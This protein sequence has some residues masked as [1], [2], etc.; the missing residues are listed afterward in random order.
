LPT[1]WKVVVSWGYFGEGVERGEG[2]EGDTF[3]YG[4]G[5]F[6]FAL[7]LRGVDGAFFRHG[8][9]LGRGVKGV[10]DDVWGVVINSR[11]ARS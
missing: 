1:W 10:R 6:S 5:F 8:C 4:F 3:F 7:G 9:V 2:E 11:Y